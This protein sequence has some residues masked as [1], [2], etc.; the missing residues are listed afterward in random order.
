M[1]SRNLIIIGFVACLLGVLGA[2]AMMLRIVP[3]SFWLSFLSYALSVVGVFLGL[4]G[5][6]NYVRLRR[7]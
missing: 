6:V 3:P 2:W 7:R 1:N 4:I 5:A